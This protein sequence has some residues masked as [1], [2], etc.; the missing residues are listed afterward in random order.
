MRA[1]LL[2]SIEL[3]AIELIELRIDVFNGVLRAG[4][5]DV[6]NGVDYSPVSL[7]PGG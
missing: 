5:N 4:D 6:F 1:D 2:Q 7:M 3:L